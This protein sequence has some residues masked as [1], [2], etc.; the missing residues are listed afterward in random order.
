MFMALVHFWVALKPLTA[1]LLYRDDMSLQVFELL[2]I[3]VTVIF[4]LACFSEC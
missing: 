3:F 1:I 2:Y 4:F